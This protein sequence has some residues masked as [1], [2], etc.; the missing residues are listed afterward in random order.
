[1][2]SYFSSYDDTASAPSFQKF[3]KLI[4]VTTAQL[5]EFRAHPGFDRAYRECLEI[6][7]D[8]ITDRAL[9][10]RFDPSFAKFLVSEEEDVFDGEVAIKLEVVE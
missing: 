5:E 4:G 6:R 9:C 10:R 8:Y 3:A 1:M 2:Y 7:R